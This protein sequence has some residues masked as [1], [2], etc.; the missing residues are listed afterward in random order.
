MNTLRTNSLFLL[1]LLLLVACEKS[2]VPQATEPPRQGNEAQ[3]VVP[4]ITPSETTT[5]Q[6]SSATV[7]LADLQ[8]TWQLTYI[9]YPEEGWVPETS[10]TTG[11]FYNKTFL[12]TATGWDVE[13]DTVELFSTTSSENR[14][15]YGSQEILVEGNRLQIGPDFNYTIRLYQEGQGLLVRAENETNDEANVYHWFQKQ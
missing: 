2:D 11:D 10:F 12:Y 8:G 14:L 13:G 1:S 3:S 7:A 9:W 15:S 4:D 6:T 5:E